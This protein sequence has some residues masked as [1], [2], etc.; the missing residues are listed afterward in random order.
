MIVILNSAHHK[1]I[2]RVAYFFCGFGESLLKP[3]CLSLACFA[4]FLSSFS[5]MSSL[6]RA[7]RFLAFSRTT[8]THTHTHNDIVS[9]WLLNCVTTGYCTSL[10]NIKYMYHMSVE[11]THTHRLTVSSLVFS[12]FVDILKVFKC[13]NGKDIILALLSDTF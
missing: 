13:L 9:L 3:S 7:T 1:T 12:I 11:E 6:R 4:L 10:V 8:H 2:C 5:L